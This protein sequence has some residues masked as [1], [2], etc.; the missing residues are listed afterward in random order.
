MIMGYAFTI[1]LLAVF[2]SIMKD[3]GRESNEHNFFDHGEEL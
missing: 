2:Y 1:L 3:I